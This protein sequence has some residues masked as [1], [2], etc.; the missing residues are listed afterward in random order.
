MY[1]LSDDDFFTLLQ[2]DINDFHSQDKVFM[3]GDWNSRTG[4]RAD[5]IVCDRNIDFIDD[6]NYLPDIPLS[7]DSVDTVCNKFGLKLI[8][9]CKSTYLRIANGRLYNS[10]DFTFTCHTGS[11]VI[12]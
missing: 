6:D 1:N 3:I 8:E 5:Y 11:S 10:N 9:L 12:V 4:A 2:T 7:R